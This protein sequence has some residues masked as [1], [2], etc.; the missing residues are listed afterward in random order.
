MDGPADADILCIGEAPGKQEN[1]RGTVFIGK[2]GDEVNQHYLPLAGLSRRTVNFTNAIRCLPTSPGGKLDSKSAKDVAL[3]QSC[4]GH[5]LL[6][7]LESRRHR[8]IVALGSFACRA[9]FGDGFDLEL[10][11]G[12]PQDTRWGAVMPM[13]HPALGIYEPKKMLMIRND[14]IRLKRFLNGTLPFPP[15]DYSNPDYRQVTDEAEIEALDPRT[16][17]A[18]DTESDKKRHPFCFTYSQ[19]P[20]TGRLV[21]ASDKH[22]MDALRRAFSRWEAPILFHNFYYDWVVC[23]RLGVQFPYRRIVDSMAECYRLGNL[24]Q[25]LKALAY[26]ELGMEMQDF[27]DLVS[28]YSREHVIN[29][30]KIAGACTWPKPEAELVQDDKTGLWKLYK[31]HGMNTK[32][33]VFFTTLAKNGD[34]DVFKAWENWEA[35]HALIQSEIGEWPGM[36]ITHVPFAKTLHY[37]CRDADAL[38]RLKPVL[39]GMRARVRKFP[40]DQWRVA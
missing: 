16:A 32:L 28:P 26:R 10:N 36:C 6:P 40:Q 9:L 27:E 34:K 14:W 19:A 23:E 7:H 8:V 24:P 18:C 4:I 13:Y 31:P 37:A 2:T 29:Y 30:Y 20:G 15:D 1:Q 3:L 17:I 22:L 12:I 21:L 39:M 5:H 25:G 11:H 35:D 38:I 33:K